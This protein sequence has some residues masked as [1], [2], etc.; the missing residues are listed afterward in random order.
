MF[1]DVLKNLKIAWVDLMGKVSLVL[2]KR[3]RRTGCKPSLNFTKKAS[4]EPDP[5]F[6]KIIH[7]GRIHGETFCRQRLEVNHLL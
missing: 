7:P 4:A 6:K 1:E 5:E 3:C 2:S